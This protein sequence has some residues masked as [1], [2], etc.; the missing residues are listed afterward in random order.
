LTRNK[1]LV[2]IIWMCLTF[3]IA[4]SVY[5]EESKQST[6]LEAVFKLNDP[7]AW[8]NGKKIVLQVPPVSINNSTLVPLRTLS[9]AIGLKLEREKKSDK[10]IISYEG[11]TIEFV[12]GHVQSLINGQAVK[13]EQPA[14]VIKGTT[15]VPLKFVANQLGLDLRYNQATKEIRISPKIVMAT[16]AN[17]EV[18]PENQ[19][20]AGKEAPT[21]KQ[22]IENPSVD[23]LTSNGGYSKSLEKI[24]LYSF[25][26]K[27][28]VAAKNNQVYILVRD[29]SKGYMIQ[30]YDPNAADKLAVVT[31]I[32]QKFNF[33]YSVKDKY[34]TN[35]TY[36]EFVPKKLIYND[37]TDTLYLLGDSLSMYPDKLRLAVFAITPEVKMVTYQLENSGYFKMED[38]F[39]STLDGET[40]YFGDPH[41][42]TIYFANKGHTLELLNSSPTSDKTQLIS[43]INK[44]TLYVYDR[45]VGTILKWTG[46][47][48]EKHA[49]SS[50][51]ADSIVYAAASF[52]YFYLI[53]DRH[54]VYQLSPD[55]DMETYA[56]L[57]KV[58]FNPGILGFPET[59]IGGLY[60]DERLKLDRY[61]LQMS[62]DSNG[63]LLLFDDGI[64]KRVNVYSNE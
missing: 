42:Q 51:N 48:L 11:V 38:A 34:K 46:K 37:V 28:I 50:I 25:G 49:K 27:S 14:V 54:V 3:A 9:D 26:T 47:G 52:G 62:V 43:S 19:V 20:E 17:E 33:E 21:L 63:N 56:E 23:Y 24:K 32:D 30:R 16:E 35:F 44:G 8:I 1:W 12:V 18:I 7:I 39:F 29:P 2:T 60:G 64:L 31:L 58:S 59:A 6:E 41:A 15:M 40:F 61:T 10:I 22:R 45:K 57:G 53:D 5:A 55:G 36:G 4:S 13:L